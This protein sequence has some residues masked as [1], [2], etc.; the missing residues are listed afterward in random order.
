MR[1]RIESQGSR[2]SRS[3]AHSLFGGSESTD[4]PTSEQEVGRRRGCLE[5]SGEMTGVVPPRG[6]NGRRSVGLS[7]GHTV[8]LKGHGVVPRRSTVT[9]PSGISGRTGP[10]DQIVRVLP[11]N[12]H[13]RSFRFQLRPERMPATDA[14][15]I[16]TSPGNQRALEPCSSIFTSWCSGPRARPLF[17]LKIPEGRCMRGPASWTI[18]LVARC[19]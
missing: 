17:R 2:P 10:I 13:D 5:G 19:R 12:Q 18:A 9:S 1:S 6:A 7:L 16:G 14:A 15:D 4:R 8:V 11:F 3:G